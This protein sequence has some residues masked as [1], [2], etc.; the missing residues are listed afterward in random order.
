MAS[1]AI[2]W[3][4]VNKSLLV[5]KNGIR[6]NKEKYC[7]Y[8]PKEMFLAIEKVVKRDVWISAEDRTPPH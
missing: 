8:L 5:N 7:R 1:A 3:Y 2:S 4:G 6:V